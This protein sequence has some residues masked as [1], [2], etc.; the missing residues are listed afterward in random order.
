MALDTSLLY[1][2][3]AASAVMHAV[4]AFLIG[5][6]IMKMSGSTWAIGLLI[7]VVFVSFFVQFGLLVALQADTCG[8]I[9]EYSLIAQGAAASTAI[10]AGFSALPVFLEYPRSIVAWLGPRLS[11]ADAAVAAK[12]EQAAVNVQKI[13]SKTPGEAVTP[14]ALDTDLSSYEAAKFGAITKA[15]AFWAGFGGAY[16]IGIGSLISTKCAGTAVKV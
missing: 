12:L 8:G 5:G 9:K 7:A 3:T 14:P 10:V 13:L 16:G 6:V 4:L 2:L 15:I 1:G 11:P